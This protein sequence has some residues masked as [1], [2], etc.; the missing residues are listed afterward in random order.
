MFITHH[1][2]AFLSKTS[3]TFLGK[4]KNTYPCS[5][6]AGNVF[7]IGDLNGRIS[8]FNEN[9]IADKIF[10]PL[11]EAE[12]IQNVLPTRTSEDSRKTN[13]Y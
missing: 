4:W 3:I 7:I 5:V 10:D 11:L 9:F 12:N 6:T 8:N 13:A 1:K 2:I